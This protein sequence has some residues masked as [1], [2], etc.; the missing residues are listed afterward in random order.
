[1]GQERKS[2]NPE[3]NLDKKFATK[4]I[5]IF[6]FSLF[7]LL[8]LHCIPIRRMWL[9]GISTVIAVSTFSIDNC[10]CQWLRQDVYVDPSSVYDLKF[11]DANTGLISSQYLNI[12]RTTNGGNNWLLLSIKINIQ[13]MQILDSTTLYGCGA[14]VNGD[15]VI[16]RTFN[17]GL[18]WDSVGISGGIYTD[19]SF[20]NRD[21]GWVSAF[22]SGPVLLRTTNGGI[23][24]TQQTSQVGYGK[25]FFLKYKI[26]GEYIGWATASGEM[27][28]TTNTGVSW[29]KIN[30]AVGPGP[31]GA[32][33][34]FINENIGLLSTKTSYLG[35]TTNSGYNWT[36]TLMPTYFGI[37]SSNFLDFFKYSNDTIYGTGGTRYVGNLRYKG[38]IWKSYDLGNNWNIQQPDTSYPYVVYEGI[39]FVDSVR[40]WTSNLHTTNA[41]GPIFISGINPNTTNIS[42][43]YKLGQ[44]YPNPFNSETLIQ[45]SLP[46]A[47]I[48]SLSVFDMLGR[49]VINIKNNEYQQPGNY[50]AKINMSKTNL[51]GGVYFYRLIAYEKY[52][53][54]IFSESKKLIYIK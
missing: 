53:G 43:D 29:I 40:G 48:V 9:I 37:G 22:T 28:K 11:F 33:L 4:K 24:L 1:M 20:I 5:T 23:T 8:I 26:N 52:S 15:G 13:E 10:M 17:K 14:R 3:S 50:Q 35:K 51:S 47:S 46:K 12:Y 36:F 45:Y 16:Y 25:V 44:N 42:T 6:I 54:F 41:G 21:T 19:I 27:W 7:L 2:S 34:F 30:S 38:V 39:D 49:E 18:T 32:I 31:S